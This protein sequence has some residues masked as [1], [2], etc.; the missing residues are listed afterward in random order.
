MKTFT[1]AAG[2]AV[3]ASAALL[4]RNDGC[5]FQLSA[6]GGQSGTL[7]QLDDGQNRL[8]GGLG[9]ATYC[10]NNGAITDKSGR[11]CVLTPDTKQFQ[12]NMGDSPDSGFSIGSDGTLQHGGD[13]TFY[14]CPADNGEYNVYTEKVDDQPKC[15]EISLNTGGKCASGGKD[16]S[17]SMSSPA[18]PAQTCPPQQT[19]TKTEQGKPSTEYKTTTVQASPSTVYKTS[20]STVQASPSTVYKTS[21]STAQASPTTVYKTETVQNTQVKPTTVYQTK[22]EEET[23]KVYKPTTVYQTSTQEETVTA[24]TPTTVYKTS[25]VQDTVSAKPTTVYQTKTEEET[26]TA[27]KPT[28]VYDTKT[29]QQTETAQTP[30]T[31]Y[32]TSTVQDTVSAKPTTVYQTKTEEETSTAVKPTTVYDTKTIQQTETAQT[33]TTVYQT[34]TEEET[35]TAVKPTTVYETKTIQQTE[36]AKQPTTVYNTKTVEETETK[37]AQPNTEYVTTTQQAKPTTVTKAATQVITKT[38][39]CSQHQPTQG[40][41]KPTKGQGK[42]TQ[43]QEGGACPT[44]LSGDYQYPHLIVPVSSEHPDKSYGTS[45]NGKMS[46]SMSSVFNFDIPK[47]YEGQTCSVVFL[48]PE[49]SDLETSDYTFNGKGSLSVDHLSS[50]ASKGTTWNSVPS[51]ESHAGSFSPQPGNSYVV[52]TGDCM[53]GTTQSYEL[54]AS[55]GL[56]LEYFQDYNPSPI[57]MYITTC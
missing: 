6:S 48:F 13:S 5:C 45:Y 4:P 25:T 9:Q 21:V 3:G 36:T 52:A 19:V 55:G 47:S 43:T 49:K 50:P 17:M 27:V 41:G 42:P 33:P 30:T 29:I 8:G 1:T 20:V 14:A 39:E 38:E 57:G 22:T 12:C 54:S 15:A 7:G 34:K 53:A 16:M 40:G 11:G 46:E 44:D 24:Q 56:D 35:S 51:M 2:L 37:K 32:K 18:G 31:V 26:S 28:T 23:S 10:I